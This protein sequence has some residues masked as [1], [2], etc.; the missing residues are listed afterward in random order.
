MDTFHYLNGKWVKENELK[1]SAFDLSV[2]RGFG[3]FDFLRTY[4]YQP[5]RLDDHINRL[6]FSA[7]LVGIK[8][9]QTKD[10]IRSIILTG[11]EKNKTFFKDFNIRIIVTGGVGPD[12]TTPG[13]PSIIVTFTNV[14][15]YSADHY[16]K[17]VK[18]ITFKT[19]RSLPLAKSLNY[20]MGV[21]ALQ[22]AQK[23]KA[24]EALYFDGKKI[25]EATTSNFFIVKKNTLQTPKDG[26]LF[27][28][29][30]R[31]ILELAKKNKI[32][33]LEQDIKM[34]DLNKAQE[35]FI[36]ASNKEIMPVIQ[37]DEMLIGEGKVGS[38]TQRLIRDYGILTGVSRL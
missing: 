11:I 25:Y 30:R 37:V 33:I 28:I 4:S 13:K 9:P 32:R 14:L 1:I 16:K 31:V 17:G 22:E 8:I 34:S 10:E 7:K 24:I 27:G 23:H 29:T 19:V 38:V 35:A 6:F 18:V 26:I 5:F 12:S 20:F 2:L 3:V 15:N 21:L 36:T